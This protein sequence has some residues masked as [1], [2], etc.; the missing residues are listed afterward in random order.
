MLWLAT[1][2]YRSGAGRGNND[3]GTI[4][5]LCSVAAKVGISSLRHC[6]PS[7]SSGRANSA[8]AVPPQYHTAHISSACRKRD[9]WPAGM[10]GGSCV[11]EALAAR[12]TIVGTCAVPHTKRLKKSRHLLWQAGGTHGV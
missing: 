7:C 11:L 1:A 10:L 12:C 3:M 6:R 5:W 2:G 9:A 4:T 8:T